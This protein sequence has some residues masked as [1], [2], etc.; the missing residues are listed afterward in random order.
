MALRIHS[1]CR[2]L[3]HSVCHSICHS[4]SHGRGIWAAVTCAAATSAP[5]ALL[6]PFNGSTA[7]LPPPA[8]PL[9]LPPRALNAEAP[10]GPRRRCWR[11]DR[12]Q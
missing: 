3:W 8:Q 6:L 1:I 10:L 9:V 5:A 12:L 7:A 11:S 2:S 4:V